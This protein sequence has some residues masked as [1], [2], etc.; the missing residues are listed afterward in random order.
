MYS[1]FFD[2]GAPLFHHLHLTDADARKV[3]MIGK[4]EGYYFPSPLNNHPGELFRFRTRCY[5][6]TGLGPS[7][8][9]YRRR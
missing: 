4:P 1:K 3:G 6:R 9:V 7:L 8:N 2:F 5:K